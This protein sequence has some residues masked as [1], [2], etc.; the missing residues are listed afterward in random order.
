MPTTKS[1]TYL[2]FEILRTLRNRRF[3]L[4]SLV[5]PLVLFYAVAGPNRHLLIQ[6]IPFPVY[7]M[8]GMMAWGTMVA[9]ISSGSR[10]AQERQ[11]GWTRQMRI[12]PL[13]T[14]AYFSAKV[15]AGY[16]MAIFS[17]AAM[18]AAGLSIGVHLDASQWATMILL[19]L[20]GLIPFAILGILLGHLL[21]VDSLGPAIGGIT[22][23]LAL[24]GGAYGPLISSGFLFQVIKCIPSY[25]LVQ[26]GKSALGE[27]G[28]W[29]P[30]A[31]IVIGVW[32]V[33]LMRLSA[34]VYARDT[35]R[36]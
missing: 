15:L 3:L 19:I 35:K 22:S 31:W 1:L 16:L 5:F 18:S 7:Y 24:L 26:A 36:V 12:T 21:P 23:V 20:I 30:E 13:T 4:F 27:S 2:R 6:G 33:V 29:P 17:I 10:I 9:V 28:W 32:T 8:T 11:V 25:W 14:R 34:R